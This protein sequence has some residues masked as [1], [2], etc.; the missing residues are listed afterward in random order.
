MYNLYKLIFISKNF[1]FIPDVLDNYNT[2]LVH[3]NIQSQ[4]L[5]SFDLYNF[6]FCKAEISA[7]LKTIILIG[8]I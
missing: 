2:H 7:T 1:P 4:L 3:F 5:S 6:N 8:C